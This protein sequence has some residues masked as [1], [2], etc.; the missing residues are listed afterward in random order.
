MPDIHI[1]RDHALGLAKAR[2]LAFKWAEQAEQKLAMECVYEEGKVAD[3]VTFTRS[4]VNGELR[5]TQDRF[6]L[7]AR[8]GF[9]LGAF[10]TRIEA[11]ITKNL[12]LLLKESDPVKAFD[13]GVAKAMARKAA[14]AAPKPPTKPATKPAPRSRKA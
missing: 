6:A 4:G 7:D 8:L 14:K 10:K 11:E 3:I 9:L 13:E 5:V 1:E 12:D 2:E